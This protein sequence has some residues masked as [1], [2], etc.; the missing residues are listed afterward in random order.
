MLRKSVLLSF[1][2]ISVF[3]LS[4]CSSKQGE[5]PSAQATVEGYASPTPDIPS[6]N[7]LIAAAL[8]NGEI[9]EE[10]AITY[11]V[12]ALFSDPRLPA[13]FQGSPGLGTDSHIIDEL[14]SRFT[15]L[16]P[17]TQQELLPF[18]MPPI[19]K[20]SWADPNL[21]DMSD[22]Q[23]HENASRYPSEGLPCNEIN[24]EFWD[25][26]TSMH[27]PVRFWW[28]KINGSQN[29]QA[30]NAYI[31][32]MDDEIWPRLTGLMGHTPLPD[33]ATPCN[34]GGPELDVY[35]SPFVGGGL[36]PQDKPPGC[37]ETPSFIVI[38][39]EEKPATLAHEFMHTIQWSYNTSADCMYPGDYAWLAEAT[40][41]WA[42]DYIYPGGNSEHWAVKYFYNPGD[43]PTLPLYQKEGYHQYGAYL[44]LFYLTK[45]FNQPS[46]VSTI[47][48]NTTSMTSLEAVDRAIPG[49]IK[50]TWGEFAI[51]NLVEPP[52]DDYQGWDNL[53]IKPSGDSL[54]KH[55][56]TAPSENDYELTPGLSPLTIYYEWFTFT[57]DASLVTFF[58]GLSFALEEES[59][60]GDMLGV[61]P[62]DDGTT[63]F[64]FFKQP[65]EKI[66]HL[67]IQAYF[68]IAGETDWHLEDWTDEKYMSFCRDA[69]EERLTDLVIVISNSSQ[70]NPI[71]ME[72]TFAPRVR[73]SDIGCWRY[74]GQASMEMTGQGEGGAF[75]DNQVLTDVTFERTDVHPNIPYPFLRYQVASGQLERTYDYQSTKGDCIGLGRV[76]SPLGP[77]NKYELSILYGAV[78]GNSARRYGGNSNS[79]VGVNV[80]FQCDAAVTSL[81]PALPWF[82]TDVLSMILEKVYKVPKGG[83]LDG[84]DD[85]LQDLD[86]AHMTYTWHL[87]PFTDKGA[88]GDSSSNLPPDNNSDS[89]APPLPG[90]GDIPSSPYMGDLKDIPAYP[91]LDSQQEQNGML[92]LKTGDSLVD[93]ANFYRETFVAQGW[94]DASSP[95]TSSENVIQLQFIKD[96][97]ITM[98]MIS[99]D[100]GVTVILIS[101]ISG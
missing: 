28:S 82:Y 80:N 42:E 46:L 62:I 91:N 7:E 75:V 59:M 65:D 27:S 97:K 19:Y 22:E 100:Q 34:G 43:I 79:D 96:R 93:V 21:G 2:I 24:T 64:A 94:T 87:E 13:E 67:K 90:G 35:I 78:N 15:K 60:A 74:S 98:V 3:L 66:K 41:T 77:R 44:Y 33:G 8:E 18:L 20:G 54:I 26:K 51:E 47:W 4:A 39:P 31:T 56:K 40:S 17:E 48:N 52:Y 5:T 63:K 25:S 99:T 70:D 89:G 14:I 37:R 38:N 16:K 84:T 88:P 83:I 81:I 92:L 86:N 6:S 55:E 1:V 32:A 61:I 68:M 10:T 30:V 53:N 57:E 9:D 72:G 76:S 85:M 58:N 12:F 101:Q 95:L 45:H 11:E 71:S 29:E 49:G 50:D 36:A 23:K 69:S 73:V